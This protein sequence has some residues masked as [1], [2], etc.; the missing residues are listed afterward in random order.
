MVKCGDWGCRPNPY[1]SHINVIHIKRCLTTFICCGCAYGCVPPRYGRSCQ[2]RF[3]FFELISAGQLH[4]WSTN[5]K[6]YYDAVVD[7][8][9]NPSRAICTSTLSTCME[10]EPLHMLLIGIQ[11]YHQ[12]VTPPLFFDPH[13]GRSCRNPLALG[14][15]WSTNHT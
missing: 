5:H 11:K 12:P 13:F 9:Q 15:N 3:W 14:H 6:S 1:S 8:A 4:N 10:F 7:E 2:P